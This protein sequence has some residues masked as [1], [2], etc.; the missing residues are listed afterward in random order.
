MEMPEFG[1][2]CHYLRGLINFPSIFVIFVDFT[3]FALYIE[4]LIDFLP[5]NC[6]RGESD[7]I[8]VK[9]RLLAEFVQLI[10]GEKNADR[11]KP[12]CDH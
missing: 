2:K 3:F 5:K 9:N 7:V 12:G 6:L 10:A 11:I 4:V 8:L 1:P